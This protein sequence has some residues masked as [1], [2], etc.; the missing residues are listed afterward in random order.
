M[1]ISQMLIQGFYQNQAQVMERA[2]IQREASQHVSAS[3]MQ[4]YQ[5]RQATMDRVAQAYDEKAVRGVQAYRNPDD[6]STVEAPDEYEHVW[7]NG[8]GEYIYSNSASYDPNVGSNQHWQ[9]L[10]KA[11]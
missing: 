4:A 8:L 3:I 2:R 6:G 1:Q 5:S 10:E 9:E 7:K 11:N